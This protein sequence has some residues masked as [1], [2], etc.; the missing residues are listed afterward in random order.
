MVNTVSSLFP[1]LAGALAANPLADAYKPVSD[2]L[3]AYT[4]LI[5]GTGTQLRQSIG[6][7]FGQQTPQEQLRSIVQ[8][9]QQQA[10]LGTPEGLVQLADALNQNPQFAGFALGMRQEAAKLAREKERGALDVELKK[11]MIEEN[12]AQAERAK[13]EPT[14]KP[15][16]VSRE[17][18]WVELE[19]KRL[20]EGL[21]KEEQNE[22]KA[23]S[24]LLLKPEKG[25]EETSTATR[26][27]LET[28][29]A[30]KSLEAMNVDWTKPLT[31]RNAALPGIVEVYQK[32]NRGAWPGTTLGSASTPT[33]K[34]P[35]PAQALSQ[36]DQQALA[37]A[38][39][40]P[41]DPRAAE[42]KRRLG[43]K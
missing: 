42:I 43:V 34:A 32:A 18:R 11:S 29:A 12:K 26:W 40:N 1:E 39:A 16:K 20:G 35:T 7:A 41:N 4:G 6:Q 23:L 30:Q 15:V 10:D 3:A 31:G 19:A 38:N 37:W 33:T 14:T 2:P 28:Q 24:K 25:S 22:Y 36:R 13:R 5:S 17:D 9:V 21:D 8:S 27:N